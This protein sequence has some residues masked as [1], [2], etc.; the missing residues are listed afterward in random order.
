MDPVAELVHDHAALNRGVVALGA[1]LAAP[2]VT[3][4]DVADEL[5]ALRE[6]LFHH[7]AQEEEGLFPFVAEAFPD[8]ADTI[9]EMARAHDGI[10]GALARA[11]HLAADDADKALVVAMFS[12]FADAYATHA[13]I[14][15]A[16]LEQL[17]P[18]LSATQRQRLADLVKDL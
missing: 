4:S 10:C 2:D 13:K 1:R 5:V 7:F 17:G 16:L 8:H 11:C 12:R 18:R 9:D 15:G 14:E 3:G 6:E